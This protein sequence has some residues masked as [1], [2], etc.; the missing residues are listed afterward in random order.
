MPQSDSQTK[1]IGGYSY[2]VS[3]LDPLTASDLLIDISKVVGP[4]LGAAAG[5]AGGDG[6]DDDKPDPEMLDR[7]I[8]GLFQ[9][10]EK[11]ELRRIINL[12]S[13][14]TQVR[15]G[16]KTPFLE[17]ILAEHFRG[18][19]GKMYEWL[20]FALKV[21]LG[22]FFSSVVPAIADAAPLI[23]ALVSPSQN[24]QPTTDEPLT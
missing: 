15:I 23:Q 10:I 16:D 11:T 5:A 4:S 19:V 14:V 1:E 21:Q 8:S 20:G 17:T 18:Q 9:R 7:A 13:T 2:T 22:D 3:M 12:L 24:S 6:S